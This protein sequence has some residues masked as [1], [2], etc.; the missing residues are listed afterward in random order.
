MKTRE[1]VVLPAPSRSSAD[2]QQHAGTTSRSVPR[3]AGLHHGAPFQRYID[4]SP[5]VLA[6]RRGLQGAFGNAFGPRPTTPQSH[7]AQR[8]GGRRAGVAEEGFVKV[9]KFVMPGSSF[10]DWITHTDKGEVGEPRDEPSGKVVSDKK[11]EH[12]GQVVIGGPNAWGGMSDTGENSIEKNVA[13]GLQEFAHQIGG[14]AE[15]SV[16]LMMKAHSRNAVAAGRLATEIK[17]Q[18]ETGSLYVNIDLVLFDPVPGPNQS[19]SNLEVDISAIDEST[20]VYSVASGWGFGFSPQ[21]VFGAKRIIVTRQDHQGGIK[22]GFLFRGK[23]YKGNRLN[24][25]PEG[26]YADS[27]QQGEAT[28]ELERVSDLDT[29]RERWQTLYQSSSAKKGDSGREDN[30]DNVLVDKFS[31][32]LEVVIGQ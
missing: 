17:K 30:V 18:F 6:Q 28:Q 27:N 9:I 2:P 12:D 3:G 31:E 13:Y 25:L 8:E 10:N 21:R 19:G 14:I 11:D 7:V 4:E 16:L 23:V 29:I 20:L 15:G 5:R 22:A 1:P 32:Q 24:N 26:V